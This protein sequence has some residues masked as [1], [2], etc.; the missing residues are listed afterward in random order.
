MRCLR[1]VCR[2]PGLRRARVIGKSIRAHCRRHDDRNPSLYIYERAGSDGIYRWFYK[3]H[4]C[5]DK[6]TLVDLIAQ[7]AGVSRHEAARILGR[8]LGEDVSTATAS[9]LTRETRDD[10]AVYDLVAEYC[11]LIA[12]VDSPFYE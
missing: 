6:G 10:A 12:W 3:C 2:S 8:Y 4:S 7:E 5:G 1:E 11:H 9:S